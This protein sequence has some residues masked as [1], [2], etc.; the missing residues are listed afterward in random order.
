MRYVILL[1]RNEQ[2]YWA[3]S[4]PERLARAERHR[5]YIEMLKAK[6]HYVHSQL[7][8]AAGSATTLRTENGKPVVTD[9]PFAEAKEQLGGLYL[10]EAK[11]LDE[12]LGLLKQMPGIERITA[13]VRPIVPLP[14]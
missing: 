14:W 5:P 11:D 2:A 4:D 7:L 9:G 12:A 13:E 1:Y 10:I 6:G 3:S 8:G